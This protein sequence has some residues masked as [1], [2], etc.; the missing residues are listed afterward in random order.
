MLRRLDNHIRMNR[1]AWNVLF[2]KDDDSKTR[3]TF[4]LHHVAFLPVLQH[5]IV[6]SDKLLELLRGIAFDAVVFTSQ[7]AVEALGGVVKDVDKSA[8][9]HDAEIYA[10]G[11][12]TA[13]S[14]RELG[15]ECKD[16]SQ[17]QFPRG[18]DAGNAG[19]L[20]T[21]VRQSAA[22]RILFLSG[23]KRLSTI[24]DGLK[25]RDF[26]ELQVY[27]T[28]PVESLDSTDRLPTELDWIVF[29]SP[30]GVDA[31]W[32]L[33]TRWPNAKLASIGPTTT[34][35]LQQRT[36]RPIVQACKPEPEELLLVMSVD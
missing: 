26:V 34:R 11:Q 32:N 21:T 24:P 36:S 22:R 23:D 4:H 6:N 28:S 20:L 27:E 10:V 35:A 15:K 30:S 13:S 29:Y 17:L 5:R 18:S 19:N 33:S 3:E 1:N 9:I 31:A 25:D 8:W 2:L 7:R 14:I 12:K 16:T